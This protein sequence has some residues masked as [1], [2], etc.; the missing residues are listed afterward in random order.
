MTPVETQAPAGPRATP[1][2]PTGPTSS[3]PPTRPRL[4][5]S[6]LAALAGVLV[7]FGTFGV[8]AVLVAA[9]GMAIGVPLDLAPGDWQRL[10]TAIAAAAALGAL[11][12]YLFGGYVAARLGGSD[13]LQHGLRV[14]TLAVVT[15]AALGLLGFAMAGPANIGA[16]LHAGGAPPVPAAGV[17]VWEVAI[18]AVIWSLLA[19]LAGSV[20]GGILGERAHR[21]QHPDRAG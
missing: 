11:L 20:T 16:H 21:R 5:A 1:T 14:F 9:A 18:K 17:Q 12:A 13:G 4:G 15:L 8:L 10:E 6:P 19:M 7:A 3:T 2:P